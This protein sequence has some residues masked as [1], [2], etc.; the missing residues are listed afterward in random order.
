M[1]ASSSSSSTSS[2]D[3]DDISKSTVVALLPLYDVTE[4][5]EEP[6]SLLLGGARTGRSEQKKP[7]KYIREE[8]Y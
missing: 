4:T 7:R 8:I 3:D 1:D 5:I 2:D 6:R